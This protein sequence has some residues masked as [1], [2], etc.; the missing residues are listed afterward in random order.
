MNNRTRQLL[1]A[2]LST[3]AEM[4]GV[5]DVSKT[6]NV[7]PTVSQKLETKAQESSAFLSAIGVYPVDELR[8]A[9]VG[10]TSGGMIASRTN[11]NNGAGDVRRQP[12]DPS[13]L[14]DREYQLA[15]TNFDT[16]LAYAK[17]DVWAK[18]PDFA[19]R[20]QAAILETIALNR[21]AIGWNGTRVAATTDRDAN[22]LGQDVNKGWLQYLRDHAPEN[23]RSDGEK[24][25]G[26]VTVGPGGDYATLDALAWD[27]R[28]QMPSW[29]RG[30]TDLVVVT[31]SELLHDKY[32]P[33]I[34][35]ER[36]P[37]E[38]IARDLIMS[39]KRLGNMQAT[40]T[41]YFPE[42]ALLITPLKNLSIYYQDGKRRRHIVE[43]P[44]YDRTADYQSSNE[45]YVVEDT[46]LAFFVE[47]IKVLDKD[48]D[49]QADA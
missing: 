41:P 49:G 37:S 34:N 22:P 13:G 17:L 31:G 39:Q 21:I 38:Q 6:F 33:L 46:D 25:A 27:A 7:D 2:Y 29:A 44:Q 42:D 43:E 19:A 16:M 12:R 32:F 3:V 35:K 9:T 14:V 15:K 10:I 23:I 36:D 28:Q 30:R 1:S 5:D 48:G 26:K 8:G 11:T 18:F 4:N 45:G 40:E 47:N 24:V 20:I